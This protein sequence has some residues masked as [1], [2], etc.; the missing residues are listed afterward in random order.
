MSISPSK[1]A[2]IS[3]FL[4]IDFGKAKIGLA[5]ADSETKIAFG[6]GVLRN[7]KKIFEE[8]KEI[9][10]KEGIGKIIVGS[11]GKKFGELLKSKLKIPVEFQSEIFSTQLAERGLKEKGA[12]KIKRF[13][14]REAARIILQSWLEKK[15]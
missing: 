12:R 13:D 11:E 14:D 6:Y 15:K 9:A 5:I 8:I 4:G 7:D 1:K 3:R 2:D 10:E